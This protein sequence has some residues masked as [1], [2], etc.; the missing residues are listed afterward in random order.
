VSGCFLLI[1]GKLWRDLKGFDERYFLYSEEADLCIRAKTDH[2]VQ[3]EVVVNAMLEHE[4]GA[5]LN[6]NATRLFYM[7]SSKILFWEKHTFFVKALLVKCVY[8]LGSFFRGVIFAFLPQK[9]QLAK[10]WI[11]LSFLLLR[12]KRVK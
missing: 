6:N 5:T 9:K 11:H 3:P 10:D 1:S 12:G 7:F 2:G 8:I 4:R